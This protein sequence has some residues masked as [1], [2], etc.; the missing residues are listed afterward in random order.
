M[1]PLGAIIQFIQRGSAAALAAWP[2]RR[3]VYLHLLCGGIF[4]ALIWWHLRPAF[5]GMASQVPAFS[6]MCNNTAELL[7]VMRA[8]TRHPWRFWEGQY[9]Y[10]YPY[11]NALINANYVC[12]VPYYLVYLLSHNACL[13]YN[14]LLLLLFF[15][16]A[17]S[18]YLLVLEWTGVASA[19]VLAGALCAFFPHRFHDLVDYHY[20]FTAM[21]ALALWAWLRFLKQGGT[22]RLAVF[23]V[24]VALKAISLDYQTI[25]LVFA[26]AIMVPMGALAYPARLREAWWRFGLMSAALLLVLAPFYYPYYLNMTRLPSIGWVSHVSGCTR[27]DFINWPELKGLFTRF[28]YNLTHLR[29]RGT[30]IPDAPLLPGA[31]A[32]TLTAVGLAWALLAPVFKGRKELLRLGLVALAVWTVLLTITPVLKRGESSFAMGPLARLVLDP[33]L[34]GFV[35]NSRAYIHNVMLCASVL[36][37]LCLGDLIGLA[38]RR[39]AW[40]GRTATGLTGVLL[41]LATLEHTVR[42]DPYGTTVPVR[43]TGV[44]AWL[45]RQRHPSPFIEFPFSRDEYNFFQAMYGVLAD[46]PTGVTIGR[47]WPQMS[48]FLMEVGNPELTSNK[49]AMLEAG[50]YRFWV[51]HQGSEALRRRVAA[52]STLQYVTNLD[53]DYIFENPRIERVLPL[54]LGVTQQWPLQFPR[55]YSI[56]VSFS[57]TSLYTYVP[58]VERPLRITCELLDADSNLLQ[59]IALKGEL[60]FMLAGP[61][62]PASITLAYDPLTQRLR[63]WYRNSG[64]F[65]MEH[66]PV[67]SMRCGEEAFAVRWIRVVL[68]QPR[69]GRAVTALIRITPTAKRWPYLWGVP[70]AMAHQACGFD[71]PETLAAIP[72]QRS[73]GAY[74]V[75][76]LG[77]PSGSPRAIVLTA[78]AALKKAPKPLTVSVSMNGEELGV[79]ALSNRWCDYTL[80]APPRLWQDVNVI[81]FRYPRTYFPCLLRES[82]DQ[83]R[84]CALFARLEARGT[85]APAAAAPPARSIAPPVPRHPAPV[86]LPVRTPLAAAPAAP[87]APVTSVAPVRPAAPAAQ[88]V[89]AMPAVQAVQRLNLLKNGAFADGLAHWSMWKAARTASNLVSIVAVA[90]SGAAVRLENPAAAMLGVQQLAVVVSGHVYRLCGAARSLGNNPARVFGGRIGFYLPRQKDHEVVWMTENPRWTERSAT[91]TNHTDDVAVVYAHLGYGAVAS[92]GEFTRIRLEDLSAPSA[93]PAAHATPTPVEPEPTSISNVIMRLSSGATNLHRSFFEALRSCRDD[94]ALLVYPGTYREANAGAEWLLT[95]KRGVRISGIGA[96]LIEVEANAPGYQI[97]VQ[98]PYNTDLRVEGLRLRTMAHVSNNALVYGVVFTGC[99]GVLVSNCIFQAEVYGTNTTCKNFIAVNGATNIVVR[100][101]AIITLDMNGS[102]SVTHLASHDAAPVEFHE[103]VFVAA[104]LQAFALGPARFYSCTAEPETS[105][106][107]DP[108]PAAT[109][110]EIEARLI[111]G[112]KFRQ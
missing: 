72:C 14:V 44:Y 68:R 25:Y 27:L 26:L 37:G 82:H 80:P 96:P 86:L 15:A 81:V 51:Q 16:N 99:R 45:E 32:L 38:W 55:I 29:E 6:D 2:V 76:C 71:P 52:E 78:M 70:A 31:V 10:P 84:R 87:A 7:S 19:G 24:I 34:L 74:S 4:V 40:L 69:P 5:P 21:C 112:V 59:R 106:G 89:P 75:V 92:S 111:G 42:L 63:A 67:A 35:R 77:R 103:S 100:H 36:A 1:K 79:C 8:A 48:Y 61:H 54:E 53:S 73:V 41:V 108:L 97:S 28:P 43:S 22:R 66:W 107:A 91:F 49:L 83:E 17:F 101:C 62:Y 33:P 90:P 60:P 64:H 65:N 12:G 98:M 30:Y 50:P 46:Q 104:S 102:N 109:A 20:Q 95:G 9:T 56:A 3:G 11:S 94:D 39:R 13:A 93:T 85:N 58:A 105:V 57:F 110:G 23:F 47:S 88:V 18:V